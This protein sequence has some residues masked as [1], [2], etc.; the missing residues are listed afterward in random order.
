MSNW[1]SCTKLFASRT[2]FCLQNDLIKLKSQTLKNEHIFTHSLEFL[3][4]RR[5]RSSYSGPTLCSG[6]G[7]VASLN[8]WWFA[9]SRVPCG[10]G[11][12]YARLTCGFCRPLPSATA[13]QQEAD[14]EV[15]TETLN[16]SS[17]GASSSTQA[18]PPETSASKEKETP[19]EKSKDSGSVSI[20]PTLLGAK[21]NLRPVP[22]CR[23]GEPRAVGTC[24]SSGC[25]WGRQGLLRPPSPQ[26]CAE[27]K[28]CPVEP[29]MMGVFCIS[30]D[31]CGSHQPQVAVEHLNCGH[32]D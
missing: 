15:N 8:T 10:P 9:R 17:Q 26:V 1:N 13:P 22:S 20:H 3:C 2:C 11:R 27:G 32:C 4:L 7:W 12:Y 19:A 24:L 5:L 18:A 23:H 30:S 29:V 16:K 31:R 21:Q 28:C 6:Q 14:P 25:R